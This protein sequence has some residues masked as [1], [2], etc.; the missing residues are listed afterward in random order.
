MS[1]AKRSV[2]QLERGFRNRMDEGVERVARQRRTHY[3]FNSDRSLQLGD[4]GEERARCSSTGAFRDAL[5]LLRILVVSKL[6]AVLD[7][8]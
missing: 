7:F 6:P 5:L 8:R 3:F 1:H 4:V 2:V